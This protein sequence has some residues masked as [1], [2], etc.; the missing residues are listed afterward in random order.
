MGIP[1]SRMNKIF[2]TH[3]HGDH[4]SDLMHIYCFGPSADRK[5]P[6]YVWGPSISNCVYTDP[7]G[8]AIGPYNDD[9]TAAYC[10]FLRQAAR[11]HTESFSFQT[12]AFTDAYIEQNQLR[13]T[14]TCPNATPAAPPDLKDGYDLV[15]FELDWTK[16][17]FDEKGQPV[18]NNVAY[19]NPDSGVK[20][21]HFPAVHA[22]QGAISYKLEWNG[23]SMIFTGD[24]K[25]NYYVVRQAT[26]GLDVLIHEMTPP[27]E[28]WVKKFTGLEPGDD[29]YDQVYADLDNVQQSSHTPAK[30][31]GYLLSLLYVP[32]RLAVGTHFPTEDDTTNDCLDA[33]RGYYPQGDLVIASDLMVLKVTK[34]AIEARRAIVSDYTWTPSDPTYMAASYDRPKYWTWEVDDDGNQVA[35]GNPYAQLDPNADT[36]PQN[37]WDV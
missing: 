6:L 10:R 3:I 37:L 29:G 22:R 1:A 20:I 16:E 23:L 11:W 4:M 30:A 33:V 19:W 25:P 24:T 31:Y 34:S 12:T 5:S 35:A 14:W 26:N 36:I 32:P 18:A 21:T 15:S 2:L 13:P 28:V 27:T 7:N 8:T 9:G 17:G